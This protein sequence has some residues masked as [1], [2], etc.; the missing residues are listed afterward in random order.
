MVPFIKGK[1]R[2]TEV[3][4]FAD[5]HRAERDEAGPAQPLQPGVTLSVSRHPYQSQEHIMTF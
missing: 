2:P 3:K 1:L 4:R 5:S